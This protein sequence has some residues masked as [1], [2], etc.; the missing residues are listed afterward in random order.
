MALLTTNITRRC[1]NESSPPADATVPS[2]AALSAILTQRLDSRRA[3]AHAW[4]TKCT[5]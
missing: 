3:Q 4:I 1:V 5:S 2:V